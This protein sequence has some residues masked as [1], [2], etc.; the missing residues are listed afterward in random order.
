MVHTAH[1]CSPMYDG[2]L[3]AFTKCLCLYSSNILFLLST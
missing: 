3:V 1:V 2:A